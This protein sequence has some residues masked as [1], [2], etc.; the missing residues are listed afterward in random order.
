MDDDD[1]TITSDIDEEMASMMFAAGLWHIEHAHWVS[2]YSKSLFYRFHF[3]V[4][5][6]S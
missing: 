6:F 1:K 5:L 2:L 4:H 3:A